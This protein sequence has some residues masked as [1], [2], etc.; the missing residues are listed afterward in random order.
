MMALRIQAALELERE[1]YAGETE[2]ANA[3]KYLFDFA[4]EQYMAVVNDQLNEEQKNLRS[5]ENDLNGLQND[6]DRMVKAS[7]DN[8]GNY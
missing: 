3:R 5:L 7:R 1:R 8:R 4:K 6:Q 2:Y